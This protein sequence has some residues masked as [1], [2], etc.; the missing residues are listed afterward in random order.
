MHLCCL[1]PLSAVKPS[2][3]ILHHAEGTGQRK[4]EEWGHKGVSHGGCGRAM[5]TD[6]LVSSSL[7]PPR[8]SP[9]SFP[10][11]PFFLALSDLRLLPEQTAHCLTYILISYPCSWEGALCF[12]NILNSGSLLGPLGPSSWRADGLVPAPARAHLHA[13]PDALRLRARWHHS[14]R[15]LR[16]P[17]H[18]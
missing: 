16:A 6:P 5:G 12:S 11:R 15:A 7:T 10:P 17:L 13:P 18:A 4:L 9:F 8:S 1:Q 3:R 14:S 2:V